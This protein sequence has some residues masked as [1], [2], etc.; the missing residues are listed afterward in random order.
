MLMSERPVES[1]PQNRVAADL[2][3]EHDEKI[4]LIKR[5]FDPFKGMWCLPGGH[6]EHGE[7][8]ETAAKR[9][10]KE[11]TGLD[12]GLK[13]LLGVYDAPGRDPRGP[14]ISLVYAATTD[15]QELSPATDA[16]DAQWFPVDDVPDELGFDHA[17]I[18]ED[19]LEQ[20]RK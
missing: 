20:R 14:I 3:I 15:E 17:Q 5:K 12:V 7:Q 2:V 1:R 10:A 11:E 8:V 16:A 19:Y 4:V 18:L 9:E 13:A 6:V